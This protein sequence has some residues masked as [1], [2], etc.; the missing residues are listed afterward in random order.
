MSDITRYMYR[1]EQLVIWEQKANVPLIRDYFKI[2]DLDAMK[3]LLTLESHN[4]ISESEKDE[5]EFIVLRPRAPRADTDNR[6]I[7]TLINVAVRYMRDMTHLR[8]NDLEQISLIL[9]VDEKRTIEILELLKNLGVIEET[10]MYRV[11]DEEEV[12]S[13]GNNWYDPFESSVQ[14]IDKGGEKE[15]QFKAG[16]EDSMYEEVERYIIEQQRFTT[17][18][19]QRR[20]NMGYARAAFMMDA[21]EE[22]GIIGPH[23]GAKPRKVLRRKLDM[24]ENKEKS[25][26]Q[27][28][29]A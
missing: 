25:D 7:H 19:L 8:K 9:G 15:L 20:F 28:D 1:A 12:A 13:A 3:I 22:N 10:P 21:L 6:E 23:N 11:L 24:P 26:E 2:S 18:M 27:R 4:V 14:L 5:G 17:S 16:V 29:E